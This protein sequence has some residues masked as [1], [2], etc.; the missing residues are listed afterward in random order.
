MRAMQWRR[1]TATIG[2]VFEVDIY[3]QQAMGSIDNQ[4]RTTLKQN[5]KLRI[6]LCFHGES[7]SPTT[8]RNESVF[9]QCCIQRD[10]SNTFVVGCPLV[11]GAY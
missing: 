10:R 5:R 6:E 7:N 8:H 3:R 4:G 11:A 1:S 9:L 2:S